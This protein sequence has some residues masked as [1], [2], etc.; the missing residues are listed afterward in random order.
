MIVMMMGVDDDDAFFICIMHSYFI[1]Y[2]LY[3]YVVMVI[4]LYCK[5]LVCNQLLLVLTFFIYTDMNLLD[6][7]DSCQC[8]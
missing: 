2:C 3:L 8:R 7:D 4:L 6:N 1:Q 5:R